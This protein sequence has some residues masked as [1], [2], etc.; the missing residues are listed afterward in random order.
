ML[1]PFEHVL[2]KGTVAVSSSRIFRDCSNCSVYTRAPSQCDSSCCRRNAQPRYNFKTSMGELT[3]CIHV[4]IRRFV[5]KTVHQSHGLT[6]LGTTNHF[7]DPKTRK[8]TVRALSILARF[9]SLI[10]QNA[11]LVNTILRGY[12]VHVIA[13]SIF[14]AIA[15]TAQRSVQPHALLP[16]DS[17]CVN[18]ESLLV[19]FGLRLWTRFF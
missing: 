16:C 1:E 4:D 10:A 13:Q 8:S 6:P 15:P 9:S 7:L 3:V 5:S 12:F 17:H 18:R 11:G 2:I 14:R 19:W